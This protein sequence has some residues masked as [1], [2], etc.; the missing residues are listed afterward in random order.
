MNAIDPVQS[1]S[2]RTECRPTGECMLCYSAPVY[3]GTAGIP[4]G[5]EISQ[6]L[7]AKLA[8][9]SGDSSAPDLAVWWIARKYGRDP[10]YSKILDQLA[11]TPT[12][13]Q[14]LLR[15]YFEPNEEDRDEGLNQ[16]TAAHRAIARGLV[17]QGFIKVIITTNFDRL[18]EKALESDAG[19]VP[20][21]LSTPD[22]VTRYSSTHSHFMLRT[23]SAW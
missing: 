19:V 7:L 14:Q 2:F 9:S 6:N 15:P 1:L 11:K 21:V 23:Q 3:P 18:I 13:R 20:T 22:Q 10:D 5:W 16:P 12:E 4:T 17:A 8:A